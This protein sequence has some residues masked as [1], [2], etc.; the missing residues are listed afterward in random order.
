[1]SNATTSNSSVQVTVRDVDSTLVLNTFDV[2]NFTEKAYTNRS[3]VFTGELQGGDTR[4]QVKPGE[5]VTLY[6]VQGSLTE[7][8]RSAV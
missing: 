6:N 8:L 3:Q 7:T 2:K 4:T 1:M 5:T